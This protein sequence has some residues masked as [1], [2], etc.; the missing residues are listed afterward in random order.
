M[1]NES[2]NQSVGVCLV[3]F[4]PISNFVS[5]HSISISSRRLTET[6]A[7][8]ECDRSHSSF[9][10]QV[11]ASLVF[12]SI[13]RTALRK[14]VEMYRSHDRHMPTGPIRPTRPYRGIDDRVFPALVL[15]LRVQRIG[16]VRPSSVGRVSITG[17]TVKY[18]GGPGST[19][20]STV[21]YCHH[22]RL[23][24]VV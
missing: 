14:S 15:T 4:D 13:T 1:I 6:S 20:H 5:F 12:F 22:Y 21:S 9:I 8:D 23:I 19:V 18:N 16:R 10:S 11:M 2:M 7:D 24:F 17:H 3:H